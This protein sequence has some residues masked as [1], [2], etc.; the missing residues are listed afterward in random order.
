MLRALTAVGSFVACLGCGSSSTSE[1]DKTPVPAPP[2]PSAQVSEGGTLPRPPEPK[3]E[4]LKSR[5]PDFV[6]TPG[7]IAKDWKDD[8]L[9]AGKKYQGKVIEVKGAALYVS[10]NDPPGSGRL[11][12]IDEGAR[13]FDAANSLIACTF[14]PEEAV[15][16]Q[17]LEELSEGQLVRLRGV[18]IAPEKGRGLVDCEFLEV[19]SSTAIPCTVSELFAAFAKSPAE[20]VQKYTDRMIVCR[21]KVVSAEKDKEL[22]GAICWEI[23]DPEG[24]GNQRIPVF[25]SASGRDRRRLESLYSVVRGQT[26]IVIGKS[27]T[28]GDPL[29]LTEARVLQVPPH[30]VVLPS[31]KR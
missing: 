13:G 9:A 19:G 7:R 29:R 6:T 25:I 26:I 3:R 4:S 5:T 2:T 14:T 16:Y 30:G 10:P 11:M 17:Q 28:H 27:D 18:G 23:A 31:S 24:D 22:G 8:Y 20:A 12:V 15:K 1:R 21:V